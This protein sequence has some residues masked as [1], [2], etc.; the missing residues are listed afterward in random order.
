MVSGS[1]LH[2]PLIRLEDNTQEDSEQYRACWARSAKIPE[3]TVIG[4]AGKVRS[5]GSYVVFNCD[6]ETANVSFEL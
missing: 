6:V 2:S 4:S 3:W 1:S 5:L